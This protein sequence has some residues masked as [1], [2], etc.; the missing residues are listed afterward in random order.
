MAELLFLG[1]EGG[2]THSVAILADGKE[3][4]VERVEG[5][6]ANLK[7]LSDGQLA[8]FLS[9]LAKRWPTPSAIGIGLAGLRS[10]ADRFRVLQVAGKVWPGIPCRACADLQTAMAA[11]TTPLP[12]KAKGSVLV[13]SGT[14]SCC[15]GERPDGMAVKVGGWGHL[16]GDKGSAYEIGLRALK[17]IVY[18][19]DRD[20]VWPT[21]GRRLLQSLRLN[22]PE[23][24]IGWAHRADKREMA[25]LAVEVFAAW[26]RRDKIASDI[27]AG[28]A[29]SLARDGAACARRLLAPHRGL[30]RF[31]LAGS[32]LLKQPRF[33][34]LVAQQLKGLWPKAEIQR[35]ERE[36]AWGAVRLAREEWTR[37]RSATLDKRSV[38]QTRTRDKGPR[39]GD[40]LS[41]IDAALADRVVIPEAT[42]LSPTERRNPRS[43]RLDRMNLS[44]AVALMLKEEG[45]V[46]GILAK[47]TGAIV[48]TIEVIVR[49]FRRG[50]RL[51]YVGAGT[52]GRLG[53]LDASECPPTFRVSAE[54]VQGIM[55]GGLKALWQSIEGAE[56]DALEGRRAV[57]TRGITRQ[58]VVVGIAAS[59]RTPFVWGALAEAKAQGAQT[60]LICFNP[61]LRF[62]RNSKPRL[63]I[64]PDLGPEVLTGSTRLKAGTATKL[65]L[66]MLTTLA[67]VRLGK[68]LSNLMVD[69]NPSNQK[70]RL[71]AVRIVRELTGA[72]EPEATAMLETT[73]WVVK[74]AIRRLLRPTQRHRS[75]PSDRPR[76]RWN[77]ADE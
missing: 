64:A 77:G 11:A 27:L 56:D 32:V 61:Y 45:R 42:S 26:K 34:D 55:A 54:Q 40:A 28:A 48:Q 49:A 31:V 66:N 59:G 24:L 70:L 2:A 14:G 36:G 75:E 8:S 13:L 17:A 3:Q 57:R 63:V 50:G 12:A 41:G 53:T 69:L 9:A 1:I 72:A 35:L 68:V 10:D 33:A 15:Y 37:G 44:E 19:A 18:Y 6:P 73:A 62:P 51:F 30:V 76:P 5:E 16:L 60:V 29:S 46:P 21:L 22:S 43:L 47:H 38:A 23:E 65:L 39:V 71:R 58:D 20:A 67:M 52:S 4:L 25:E 74:D 7:L